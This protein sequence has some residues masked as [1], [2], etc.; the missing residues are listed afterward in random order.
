MQ[1]LRLPARLTVEQTG[2]LLGFHP[3]AVYF[4][5]KRGL[6]RALGE[7][8]DVQLMFAAIHI[9]RLCSDER[10]LAKATNAVR[11]HHRARNAA[12]KS[13]RLGAG[14]SIGSGSDLE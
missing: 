8:N 4:L 12:Q 1:Q 5:A 13:R 6:L 10:W 11:A 7:G 3:D 14:R 9:L 2:A